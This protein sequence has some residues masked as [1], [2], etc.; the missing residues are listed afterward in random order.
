MSTRKV[1]LWLLGVSVLLAGVVSLYASSSPDG[2]ERVAEDLGFL[3]TA[4]DSA[5]SSSP[6]ADYGFA[7]LG[8]TT[9]ASVVSGLAGVIAIAGLGYLL[10]LWTRAPRD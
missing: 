8:D 2:L 1:Y 5:S 9:L 3:D 7:F 6:L 4:S 10:F